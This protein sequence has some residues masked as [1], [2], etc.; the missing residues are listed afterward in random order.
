MA[1]L[2]DYDPAFECLGYIWYYGRTKEKLSYIPEKDNVIFSRLLD[3]GKLLKAK[4][5]SVEK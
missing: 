3:A 2:K 5:N 1:A 4:V